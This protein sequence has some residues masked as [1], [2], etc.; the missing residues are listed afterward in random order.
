[1][2]LRVKVFTVPG[3]VLHA[4]TRRLVLQGADGVAFIADSQIRE[5]EHNAASFV[6]LRANLKELGLSR[7]TE[8]RSSSSSTSATCPTSAPTRRSRSLASRGREPVFKA[9]AVT[10]ERRPRVVLRPP[11]AS[12]GP[13]STPSTS[14]AKK[15]GIDRDSVLADGGARSS[16]SGETSKTLL[17]AASAAPNDRPGAAADDRR[18]CATVDPLDANMRSSRA[19]PR[20]ARQPRSAH[21]AAA[22]ASTR[23]SASRFASTRAR[24]RCSPTSSKEQEVCAYVNTLVQGRAACASIVGEVKRLDPGDEGDVDPPLLHRRALPRHRDRVRRAADRPAHRRAVPPGADGRRCRPSLARDRPP[25][26]TPTKAKS[27]LLKMPRAK[28]ETITRHRASTSRRRST[29][30]SSAA[31]RRS[32]R[33]HA[34]RERDAR[35]TASCEEKNRKLQEAYDRLKELDRLKSNFLATVSHELRTPLTSIIGYSEMLHRGDRG[36]AAGRADGVRA[37]DPREGGAAPLAHHEPP[38]S[39]EAR[40]R[41][42]W[43]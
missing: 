28:S 40:E 34:P 41:H 32:S 35:A 22:R 6:D 3:Q 9:S 42:A 20:G 30:S 8:C 33:A 12:R 25:G 17:A 38:R 31:T 5:T 36:R 23:S 1:M 21:R 43:P 26:S 2:S 11:A 16:A 14:S 4:S 39:V 37:D 24:A 19:P 27:L 10:G 15:L 7:R 13:S 18:R 29:S